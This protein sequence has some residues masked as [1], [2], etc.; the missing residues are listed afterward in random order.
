MA[1]S[2][3]PFSV[4]FRHWAIA[5]FDWRK[6]KRSITLPGK[7]IRVAG[8]LHADLPQH[9]GDDDLDVLVVD[10][11]ALAAVHVLNF[12]HQ[13]LLHGLFAGDPQDVVRHE[14][15]IDERVARTH[16]VARVDAQVLVVR[17][18]VLA[19]DAALAADDDRPLAA[20][21]LGQELDRAVD[22][23]DDR[24]ILR[25]AGFE[26]F[27]HARQTARDVLRAGR[28]ARRLG[29]HRTRA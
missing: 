5:S 13:V 2:L 27:R 6:S 24:R 3:S 18:Q 22:F 14:R 7:Q 8:R 25:L 11:D 16:D 26:D 9:A 4:I 19:F 12:T 15:T 17:D 10:L 28:L 23:G 21:L 20:L 29:D 1:Y